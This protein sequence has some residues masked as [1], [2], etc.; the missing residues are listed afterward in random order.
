MTGK[1]QQIVFGD[2]F[3]ED[4]RVWKDCA[5]HDSPGDDAIFSHGTRREKISAAENCFAEKCASYSVSDGVHE[6]RFR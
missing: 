2:E 1:H 4:V 6:R 3:A 5:E